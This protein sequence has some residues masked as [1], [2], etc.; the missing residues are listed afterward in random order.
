M[1]C[2]CACA[3]A[4]P[5]APTSA[6]QSPRRSPFTGEELDKL[7][8]DLDDVSSLLTDVMCSMSYGPSWDRQSM[9]RCGAFARGAQALVDRLRDICDA[10]FEAERRQ[11]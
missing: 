8:A 11:S 2:T 7:S 9:N 10:H 3:F 1:T 5:S 6:E 4:P